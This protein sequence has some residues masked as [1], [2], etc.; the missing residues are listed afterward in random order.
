MSC[1]KKGRLI[2]LEIKLNRYIN[3]NNKT[4]IIK[5]EDEKL[6]S[7]IKYVKLLKQQKEEKILYF[8]KITNQKFLLYLQY[9]IRKII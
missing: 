1:S 2:I 9:L 3:F 8:K 4:I 5:K 7:I 6:F